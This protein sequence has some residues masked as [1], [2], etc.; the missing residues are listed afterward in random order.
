VPL[1]RGFSQAHAC[2]GSEGP[3]GVH[4]DQARTALPGASCPAISTLPD[5][6]GAKC[7]Q[8]AKTL[9]SLLCAL[10]RTAPAK[11]ASHSTGGREVQRYQDDL[12]RCVAG[13]GTVPR[14]AQHNGTMH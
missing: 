7:V 10:C 14:S 5:G 2:L 1:I 11:A 6:A 9:S 4:G 8:C 3:I 13:I 12:V